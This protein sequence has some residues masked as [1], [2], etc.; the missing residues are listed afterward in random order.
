M[1][2]EGFH[3]RME[4][5][6]SYLNICHPSLLSVRDGVKYK[7]PCVKKALEGMELRGGKSAQ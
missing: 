6:G 3:I 5:K 2:A 1:V 4:Y 7:I